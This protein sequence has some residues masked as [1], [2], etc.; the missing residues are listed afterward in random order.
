MRA[1]LALYKM[2]DYADDK[3]L[4]KV[5]PG[6]PRM[7]TQRQES[8]SSIMLSCVFYLPSQS[9]TPGN[10]G[11]DRS[12]GTED[13]ARFYLGAL[14]SHVNIECF[15]R[16]ADERYQDCSDTAWLSV[17]GPLGKQC[18][19]NVSF[20]YCSFD[21]LSGSFGHSIF[22]D[23]TRRFGDLRTRKCGCTSMGPSRG[24]GGS[25]PACGG[26]S[27]VAQGTR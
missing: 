2:T 9:E 15:C 18:N 11:A 1:L 6:M 8:K 4:I 27:A 20:T 19:T 17:P 10:S 24:R 21:R 23:H 26:D 25:H 5:D 3:E 13:E 7:R 22:S 14:R 12:H 16:D